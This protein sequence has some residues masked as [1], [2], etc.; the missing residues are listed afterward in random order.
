MLFLVKR[1][2]L[3]KSK[4]Q[5]S[6]KG[7]WKFIYRNKWNGFYKA[8]LVASFLLIF[9]AFAN[10][11][12]DEDAMNAKET[13]DTCDYFSPGAESC[14]DARNEWAQEI[15]TSW[16]LATLGLVGIASTVVAIDRPS[17]KNNKKTSRGN[18]YSHLMASEE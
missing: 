1:A 4:E 12:L 8:A 10:V 18:Y 11:W 14:A 13:A 2:G 17:D 6:S 9:G 3:R 5:M 7:K 16:S 15:Q